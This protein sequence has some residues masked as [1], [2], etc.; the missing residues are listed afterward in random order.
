MS[1]DF[2]CPTAN[3]GAMAPSHEQP[4]ARSATTPPPAA[5]IPGGF[6]DELHEPPIRPGGPVEYARKRR[7]R[8]LPVPITRGELAAHALVAKNVLPGRPETKLLELGDPE[9]AKSAPTT[10]APG[11]LS[12]RRSPARNPRTAAAES[13]HPSRSSVPHRRF[14]ADSD[15][16][17]CN[18][19][20]HCVRTSAR[21]SSRSG[22]P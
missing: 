2:R 17:S 9:A 4:R 7:Q 14:P 22:D 13:P 21:H 5:T 1:D 15:A 16:R 11:D 8:E 20:E 18:R 3:T 10:P 12:A 19:A 6:S